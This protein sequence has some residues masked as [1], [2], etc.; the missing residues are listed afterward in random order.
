NGSADELAALF[1]EDTTWRDF[2]AFPWDFHHAVGRDETVTQLIEFAKAW[3]ATGFT[4][5]REQA[6]IVRD[7]SINAFFDF[8]TKNRVD[9]GYVRLVRSDGQYLGVVLQTQVVG[10]REF[11][12]RTRHNRKEG[13][14]YGVVP[15]RTRWSSDR[16]KEAAFEDD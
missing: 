3:D 4:L 14:V 5:S 2:M 1:V 6:P 13:K 16:A 7:D 15:D 12:E 8:T 11:S 10:L 9:R